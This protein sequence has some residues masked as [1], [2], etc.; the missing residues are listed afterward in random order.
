MAEGEEAPPPAEVE[1]TPPAG[2]E[3][4]PAEGAEEAPPAE[5]AEAPPAEEAEVMPE[6]EDVEAAAAKIQAIQRGKTA[7]CAALLI[8]PVVGRPGCPGRAPL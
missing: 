3:G 2:G 6:G 5:A 1:E 8:S 7:R 4:A